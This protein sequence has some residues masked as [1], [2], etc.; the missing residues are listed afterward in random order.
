MG[1]EW[2][3]LLAE[4]QSAVAEFGRVTDA[5]ST[6]LVDPNSG[7]ET[8]AALFAAEA[9]ARDR[10]ILTRMR[11]MNAWR[12]TQPDAQELQALLADSRDSSRASRQ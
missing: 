2:P 12:E 9:S 6:A 10:V 5:L 3:A 8:F 1:A 4:Y 7:A 11:L